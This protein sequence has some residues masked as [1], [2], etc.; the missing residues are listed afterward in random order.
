LKTA[1][2]A[3]ACDARERSGFSNGSPEFMLLIRN[4]GTM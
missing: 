3:I 2:R 1:S 4:S